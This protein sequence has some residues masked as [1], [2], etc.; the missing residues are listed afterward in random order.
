MVGNNTPSV[1]L[2]DDDRAMG[3]AYTNVLKP[4]GT[5]H[6]L[7]QWHL[8]KNVMKNLIG[9]L[10]NTWNSFIGQ[11]YKCLGKLDPCDFQAEWENLKTLY[12]DITSYLLRMERV[13]EKWA[14]CFNKDIF[15]ADMVTTQRAESM[16]NLM[17]RYLDAS[18][19]LTEFLSAFESVLDARKE[20]TEF[21]EYKQNHHN[22]MLK[23]SSPFEKQA[24]SL[25]TNY[26]FKKTQ[27]QI[28]ESFSYKCE[29]IE[30]YVYFINLNC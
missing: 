27:E 6:R 23:T 2:T 12:P 25:L 13:K 20:S 21:S 28:I 11:L 10:G 19:S 8:L 14:A 16:N 30:W 5:R 18:T 26:S 22:V 4:L 7:C 15:T 9:K 24:A 3:N 1:I 17:K 29:E